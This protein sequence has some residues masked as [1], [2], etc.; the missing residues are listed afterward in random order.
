MAKSPLAKNSQTAKYIRNSKNVIPLH[1]T[2]PYK[3]IKNR[4]ITEFDVSH[5]LHLGA[6]SNNEKIQNRTPYLRSF[7]KKAKQYIKQGK[8]ATSVTSYYDSLRSLILFCD[9]V[10][11][12][13]FSKAGYLKFAGN[14]GELRHRMKM[15]CPSK[16]LWERSHN[17][18]LGIKESTASA[19][20]SSLRTALKWCGLPINSWG[21]LHRGFSGGEKMPYKGYSDS[22]EKI[23]ISRL[24]E[25]FFTLAPQLIAAKKENLKL[26]DILP[27]IVDLGSHQEVISIQTHLKTQD[28]NVIS[29]RPSSAFNMV[30]G[31]AYHLMCFFSSLNDSDVKGIAHPLTIH[32]DE[33]DKSLQVVKVSSFKARAN[34]EI[35]AILTNQSFDVDKR[36]GVNFITTLETL[37]ALYGGNEEGSELIFTLN[38]QGEKSDTFNLGELNK[39]LMVELNLLAPTRKSN[40]P[41]FKELFYSYRNQ[42]VIQLKT[43]TN[44]L[45]RVIVSKVTRPCSKT[46]A[47]RGATSAAYCILSCYTDLPLKGVLLPLSYSKKDSDGNIHVSLK[48]RDNSIHEF[49]IPA[50]DKTLIQDIEQFATDLADKQKHRNNE[51]LLLKRGNAHQAPKDWDG[52]SPIT[53]NLMRTWSI[54]PNEYFISLQSSR[55]RE[56]TSNQVYSENGKEGVQNLLQ[57]LLQTI[58]KHYVNGDPKL[59]K[60][61]ISQAMQVMEQLGEDTNL[62]QVRAKVV[63]KLGIKMLAYDEWKKKQ[64]NERAKTNP[65]GIHCNGQQSIPGGKNSQRETNKAIGF[66]LPCTEYDMCHKCQSAKAVDEVQSIYKLI[67]F[68]DVLKEALDRYPTTTEE[69]NERIAAFEFTLDGASKDVYENAM[70]LFNKKGRHPRISIDHAILAL[71]R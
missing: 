48:Y 24:S 45:G 66:T 59:N 6:N 10:N 38:S 36:D 26:P 63:A 11:V 71:Y 64:E 28:Q 39:H 40:L 4:T 9:A 1:L 55:W 29:V 50:A 19:I 54:D 51:R 23:L 47:T 70:K 52:I 67:S 8:S 15:Y 32:T 53:S 46:G 2:I 69:I 30:M 7:C 21:T 58:D 44:E 31:A 61:I 5:L 42:R 35:D 16:K 57:N 3:N 34:K 43:E 13:P 18:E 20:M 25:L 17:A 62:E 27:V 56:M 68:I 12:P 60:L 22:E 41:W 33:R 65:N 14:D 49:S 37:S